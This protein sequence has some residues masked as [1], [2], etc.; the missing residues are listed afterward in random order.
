[1]SLAQSTN[2][3]RLQILRIF[4]FIMKKIICVIFKIAKQYL[5]IEYSSFFNRKK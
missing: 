4:M 1:M 5:N 3:R 2:K